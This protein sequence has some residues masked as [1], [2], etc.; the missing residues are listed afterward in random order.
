[1]TPRAR[2][3]WQ[4][5]EDEADEPAGVP[6]PWADREL[7]AAALTA[8]QRDLLTGLD[9]QPDGPR[10]HGLGAPGGDGTPVDDQPRPPRLRPGNGTG[11]PPGDPAGSDPYGRRRWTEPEHQA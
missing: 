8:A 3:W 7:L 11:N 5:V 10:L 6:E 1:M 4:A 2:R 9:D